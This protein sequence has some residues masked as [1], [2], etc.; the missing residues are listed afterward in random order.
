MSVR[1]EDLPADFVIGTATAA[2][3]VEGATREDGRGESIWDA[4]ARVPGAIADGSTGDVADDHYHRLH[5]D[6]ELMASLGVDAYR[7]SISWPRIQPDGTGPLNPAGLAFYRELALALVAK[8]ITPYATLYHWDLPQT[9]Q[10]RGGWLNRDTADRFAAYARMT[11]AGLGDVVQ[12]WITLNEPWCS[13]FLS[14]AGGE[15]APGLQVGTDAAR[16]AH[17]LLLAHGKAVPLMR[18][19]APDAVVGITLN[20]YSVVPASEDPADVDAARRI[21]GLSNR[22]FL[23][24][25]LRGEYPADVLDDL[26]QRDWFAEHAGAE[27]L[28]AVSAPIDFLGVNYYSRHT[29]RAGVA[30]SGRSPHPGSESVEMVD[31]GA[32]RTH[33]GWEVH[34]DGL[35]DVLRMVEARSPGLPTYITENGAAYEDAV[36]PDGVVHDEDR[37][38]YLEQH[39]V[40]CADAVREGLPLRGYFI[41]TLLDNF[42]WAWGYSRRFGI[43]HVDYA[44]Q[45]RTPKDSGRWLA[46]FLGGT[47][48][49]D[50]G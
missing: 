31:T 50:R 1:R 5:E 23:D 18:A 15:H 36:G 26:G 4:F 46:G 44:T 8:G 33:M 21:D 17:H 48:G 9:L 25:V 27:D 30:T 2:Y 28:A 32:P 43:V 14:Y 6:I 12:H 42:E 24:P 3:Q 37:R 16:A 29:T 38:A 10:D 40:A 11:V 7:F 13:S 34:P 41:W 35:V 49:A 19:A 22:F 39:L 47:L 20:L 45:R